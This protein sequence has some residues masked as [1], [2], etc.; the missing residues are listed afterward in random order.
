MSSNLIY[1]K[2]IMHN[3]GREPIGCEIIMNESQTKIV[4]IESKNK[5]NIT[6]IF[7]N[8]IVKVNLRI[9]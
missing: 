3:L 9:W 2:T 1:R 8:S 4:K 5:N 6:I 7:S